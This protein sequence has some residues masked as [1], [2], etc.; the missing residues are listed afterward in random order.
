MYIVIVKRRVL[1]KSATYSRS[2]IHV[3]SSQ[4]ILLTVGWC[5][6]KGPKLVGKGCENDSVAGM[7]EHFAED[8]LESK[9]LTYMSS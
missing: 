8:I 1:V 5:V 9:A 7:Q 4:H 6:E 2:P 3:H